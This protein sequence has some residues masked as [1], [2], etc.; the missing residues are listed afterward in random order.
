MNMYIFSF[1]SLSSALVL[2]QLTMSQ[3]RVWFVDFCNVA[4]VRIDS[5]RSMS[6]QAKAI[7]PRVGYLC[8]LAGVRPTTLEEKFFPEAIQL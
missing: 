1:E 6:E 2:S 4:T 5:I 8:Q 3:F 7:C